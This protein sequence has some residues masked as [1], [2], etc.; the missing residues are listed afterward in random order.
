LEAIATANYLVL[1]IFYL[2]KQPLQRLQRQL[3]RH[4]CNL[5]IAVAMAIN[6]TVASRCKPLQRLNTLSW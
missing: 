4:R 5:P 2:Q 6:R 1:V 3:Q